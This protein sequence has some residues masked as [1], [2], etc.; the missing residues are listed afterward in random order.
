MPRFRFV[1][2][3]IVR[4]P[5]SEGDWIDVK[6]TLNVGEQKRL[7]AT[8]I[9]RSAAAPLMLDWSEYNIGRAAVWLTDWS[10]KD[11][12]GKDVRLTEAAIRSLDVESFEE[13]QNALTAH[14]KGIE[15]AKKAK[16]STPT[17]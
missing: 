1:V 12:D 13:I 7:E 3:E 8:G 16:A 14:V 6:K 11:E 17:V 15:E 5:L 10:F 4:L 9:A 2:P